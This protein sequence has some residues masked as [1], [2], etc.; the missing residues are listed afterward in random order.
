MNYELQNLFLNF[1]FYDLVLWFMVSIC[2]TLQH[3]INR[4]MKQTKEGHLGIEEAK[5]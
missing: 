2:H 4:V 1:E 5:A 3:I